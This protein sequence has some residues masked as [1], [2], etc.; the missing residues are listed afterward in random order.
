MEWYVVNTFSGYE[1]SVKK[2]LEDRIKNAGLEEQFGVPLLE[3]MGMTEASSTI[4]SQTLPPAVRKLGSIGVPCG[5][6]VK[7]IDAGGNALGD[8][9]PGEIVVR[10]PSIMRHYFRN[11]AAT[12]EVLDHDEDHA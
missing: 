3:A 6:A 12:A 9:E 1:N 5:F 4:F 8:G 7:V 2:A 10:G 11:P